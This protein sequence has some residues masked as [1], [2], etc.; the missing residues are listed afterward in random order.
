MFA[1][2][3]TAICSLL[4]EFYTFGCE[5]LIFFSSR[6]ASLKF[7]VFFYCLSIHYFCCFVLF[8]FLKELALDPRSND[9]VSCESLTGMEMCVCSF[10]LTVDIFILFRS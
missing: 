2:G 10:V 9:F 5:R 3:L 1:E 7:A 8:L 4:D 6:F